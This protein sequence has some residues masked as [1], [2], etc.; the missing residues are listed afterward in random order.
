VDGVGVRVSGR[1]LR[2]VALASVIANVGIVV[3]GGAVRLTGSGLGCPT[4]PRCTDNSYVPTSAMGVHGLIEFTNRSLTGVL[5]VVVVAGLL[6]AWLARPRRRRVVRLATV[7]L[8]GIPAQIALGGVTV[9]THL[10]PWVVGCHFLLSIG[11]IAAAYAFWRATREG[12]GPPR[13]EVPVPLRT[14]AAAV[15]AA[16]GAVVV[17]GTVVTGS[18]PHAGDE[19]ARRNGLDPAAVAQVHA[20]LVFLVIGLA[21]AAWLA[22]LA[23][24]AR[25]AAGR[26]GWLVAVVLGQGVI[27][28]VQYAT[29]LPAILVGA[30]LLG[31]CLVWLT[32]L[33]LWYATRT[34]ALPALPSASVG[35]S[36]ASGASERATVGHSPG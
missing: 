11:V 31:A 13:A 27:G 30:H 21:V 32:A 36:P 14:L 10:N 12:D 23:V 15:L 33:S 19:N 6:A 20:D 28:F 29:G 25:P 16:V 7:T 18:G 9:R 3:T 34:R 8:L 17:V 1:T 35:Q 5:S 2:G 4:W 26:A 22:L 24:R